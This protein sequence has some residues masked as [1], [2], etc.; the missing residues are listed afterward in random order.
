MVPALPC[1]GRDLRRSSLSE[2]GLAGPILSLDVEIKKGKGLVRT[3]E[4]KKYGEGT[5][6]LK[7]EETMKPETRRTRQCVPK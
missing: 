3:H 4:P 7:K 1:V 2:D 6:G 5:S